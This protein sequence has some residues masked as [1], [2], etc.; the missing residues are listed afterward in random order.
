MSKVRATRRLVSR[1][2]AVG[3]A[4]GLVCTGTIAY[5]G[6]YYGGHHGAY[7]GGH[8]G[9]GHYGHR[10]YGHRYYGH[11]SY[12]HGYYGRGHYA[13]RHGYVPGVLSIPGAVIDS[14]FGHYDRPHRSGRD[15]YRPSQYDGADPGDT[16]PPA[17]APDDTGASL[18]HGWGQLAD[19]RYSQALSTFSRE[20][21]SDPRN[22]G[23]TVGFA[24]S[25]AA[26]GDL[27]RGVWAM[28]RAVRLD[29]DAMH[30]VTIDA[31]LRPRLEELVTHY[32]G[33]A[34]PAVDSAE[35]AFML[36]SLHYLLGDID[37]AK[38]AIVLA[39]AEGDRDSS[40]ANLRH[41]VDQELGDGPRQ[42]GGGNH[43]TVARL[44]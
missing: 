21:L 34:Y 32:R 4:L 15:R 16:A 26:M 20:A 6:G 9:H 1:I 33:N 7:Y 40:T 39:V 5:A 14:L 22:G 19:G 42:E 44:R 25:A 24:L 8:H 31:A 18:G 37:S 41:L 38:S 11:R 3:L 13:Y 23:S 10:Y 27:A 43:A 30:Y 12:G 2:A 17:A 28:R 35:A 29:P 36:A